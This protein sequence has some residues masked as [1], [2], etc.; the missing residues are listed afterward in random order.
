MPHRLKSKWEPEQ[1]CLIGASTGGT[2]ALKKL[3]AALPAEDLS[4][5]L[6]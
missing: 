4:Y 2:V 3:L 5:K 6:S 1:I